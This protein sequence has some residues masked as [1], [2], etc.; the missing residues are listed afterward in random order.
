MALGIEIFGRSDIGRVREANEDNF[1]CLDLFAEATPPPAWPWLLAVADG[2][3]GHAGGALASALAVRTLKEEVLA[4]LQGEPA[5]NP[6]TVLERAFQQANRKVF[7]T[8]AGL[9]NSAG[10][11]TTLVALLAGPERAVVSN[12][13]DSRAYLFRDGALY[14]ITKDHSWASEQRKMNILTPREIEQSPFRT[15][16]TRS[17]GY[18]SDVKV[19]S[20][21]V[22]LE[23][24][25]DLFLC[26]DG[27]YGPVPEK[28]ICRVFKKAKSS[29]SICTDLVNLAN[30]NG[31]PDNIT[32][33]VGRLRA[34]GKTPHVPLNGTLMIKPPKSKESRR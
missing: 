31:G 28:K 21:I 17:L 20:F 23:P 24:G 19:D 10:M 1:L 9:P 16:V 32:A 26:T 7:E 34:G 33:V 29:L 14:Q 22:E 25:D 30:K 5:S 13:G 8:A 27:L 4:M 15:L 2:I 3:G 6:E 11:G 18:E 12:V